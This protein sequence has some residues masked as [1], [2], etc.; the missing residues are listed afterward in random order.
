MFFAPDNGVSSSPV[1]KSPWD[2]PPRGVPKDGEHIDRER[3]LTMSNTLT[4]AK[5]ARDR[6]FNELNAL[7]I[8]H[9]VVSAEARAAP[10]EEKVEATRRA[11]VMKAKIATLSQSFKDAERAMKE[12]EKSAAK[13][14]RKE[15][16]EQR[17]EEAESNPLLAFEVDYPALGEWLARRAKDRLCYVKGAGWGVWTESH[18]EFTLEPS[19]Q[20]LDRVRSLYK[21]EDTDVSV[22]LKSNARSANYILDHAQ[23]A[24]TLDRGLF[25]R[26]D[27]AHLIAYKNV[28]VDLKTGKTMPHNPQHYM[29]GALRCR[30]NLDA[31]LD[32]V[33]TAFSRFWPGDKDTADMFQTVVGYAL[34]GETAAKI[35]PMLVGNQ[36]NANDNGDNG[37]SLVQNALA[38]MF[39]LGSGGWGSGVKGSLIVDTGDRDANSHDAAKA[40]L[41]WRR[42]AMASEMRKGASVDAGEFNRMSGGDVQTARMPH[43][44]ET[45]EFVNFCTVFLSFNS[46]PRFKTWDKATKKRLCSFPFYETFYEP[47]TAPAGK[48]EQE[49]GLDSWLRS[50]EGLDALGLYAANGAMRYYALNGGQAGR[51]PVSDAVARLRDEI[52]QASNP[53]QQFF[54]ENLFFDEN[55]DASSTAVSYLFET[56]LGRR[57]KN[58]ERDTLRSAL[59]QF[60]VGKVKVKGVEYWRGVGLLP[61]AI[62]ASN[63]RLSGATAIVWR[64]GKTPEKAYLKQVQ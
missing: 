63:H 39:G 9:A 11:A 20:I 61:D 29:T 22:K 35:T 3:Y 36:E 43:N 57:P 23:G 55:V 12:Q 21:N 37:K 62:K 10:K 64:G 40:P 8:E 16:I 58:H 46:A 18:W 48:Q 50:E 2:W 26:P 31:N 1:E 28:T 24:L 19:A 15:Y 17:A 60:G 6:L 42:Y 45:V 56:Y 27:V 32:R 47:G 33:L 5:E 13:K 25:N 59:G 41:I 14:E 54:E 34:T 44:P 7:K 53:F 30:Y 52:L 49:L 38:G 51:I 4:S